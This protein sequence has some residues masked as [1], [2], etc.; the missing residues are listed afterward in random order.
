MMVELNERFGDASF[1][2]MVVKLAKGDTL[3]ASTLFN[4]ISANKMLDTINYER[5]SILYQKWFKI[6]ANNQGTLQNMQGTNSGLYGVAASSAY[7]GAV[8]SR[9]TRIIKITLPYKKFVRSGVVVYENGS[10]QPK[11]FDYKV[12]IFGHSNWSTS[13]AV[14][15]GGPYNVGR[16]NDYVKTIN[17]TDS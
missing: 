10:S 6:K 3:N 2:V 7:Q 11:F 13:D 16:L 9:A 15:T 1:R 5:Y 8:L 14:L 4:G 17:F 12:I